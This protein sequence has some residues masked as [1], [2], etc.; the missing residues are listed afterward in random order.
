MNVCKK[1]YPDEKV[2]LEINS[3]FEKLKDRG[4]IKFYDD[5]NQ[6]QK[7]KLNS[8]TGYTIPWDIVWKES[9]LSTPA[10][11]VYDASSKTASGFSLNDIL[12]T[13]I[14]DLAKLLDVLLDWHI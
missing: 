12:A 4:H 1:Y 9:S 3:A 5:L 8:E 13:G 2:K 11:T 14:P 7:E 6:D 10:R